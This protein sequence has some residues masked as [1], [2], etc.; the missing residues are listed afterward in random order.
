MF[1]YIDKD[2]FLIKSTVELNSDSLTPITKE[3]YEERMAAAAQ[4]VN[5]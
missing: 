2:N 4:G 3:E 1:Y 5:E